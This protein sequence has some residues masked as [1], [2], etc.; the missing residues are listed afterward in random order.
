[1]S[2][3]A[4]AIAG[5]PPVAVADLARRFEAWLPDYMAGSDD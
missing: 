1:M 3:K 5:E 4:I 2:G